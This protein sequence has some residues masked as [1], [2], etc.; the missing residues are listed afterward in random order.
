M[1]GLFCVQGKLDTCHI[2]K[3]YFCINSVFLLGSNFFKFSVEGK[4]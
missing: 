2:L 4:Q 1:H 3:I